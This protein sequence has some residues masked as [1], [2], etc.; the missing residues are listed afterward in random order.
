MRFRMWSRSVGY[1]LGLPRRF[2]DPR[3]AVGGRE[4]GGRGFGRLRVEGAG[5]GVDS[6]RERKWSGGGCGHYWDG[7]EGRSIRMNMIILET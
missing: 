7:G 3:R 4:E 6:L 2:W 5:C 1:A